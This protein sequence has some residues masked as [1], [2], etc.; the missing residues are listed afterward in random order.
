[1]NGSIYNG[2]SAIISFQGALDIESNNVANVN[3]IGF[4][5]DSVSFNDLM[6]QDGVGKGVTRNDPLKD[7]SQGG[8][9]PSN[10][11]YDFAISG[12]G[13]FTLQDPMEPEKLFYSRTGQFSSNNENFLTNSEG[14]IVMGVAPTVTGDVITSE[15]ENN[16]TSTVVDTADSF[17]TLNTYTSNYTRDAKEMQSVITNLSTIEAVINGTAT[18]EEN[19]IIAANPSLMENYEKYKTQIEN[20]Q[21][22]TSGDNY[23]SIDTILNDID[24]IITNYSNALK[25]FSVNSV[26]GEIASKAKSSVVF[27]TTLTENSVNTIEISINGIKVQQNFDTS[28]ENTLKLFSDKINLLAGVTSS[29]DSTTGELTIDSMISGQN[30]IVKNAKV[31]DQML[32]VDKIQEASGSGENLIT[33]LYADLQE[34]LAKVGASAVTN[35]SEIADIQSG[36]VPP[37][38]AIR[39]DLNELGMSTTLYEKIVNGNSLATASYPQ[40]E[41]EDGNIYL[42]DGDARFLVGRL[43]PVTFTNVSGLEP[44]GDNVYTQGRDQKEPIYIA[45]SAEVMGKF[46]ENSNIDLSESLVNL[47]IWQ[48]GFEAN[49]K[50]ITT[51]D[52]LLKTALALK[53][54]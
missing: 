32:S 5:S 38:E 46:V 21:T 28:M 54:T 40:I 27:P 18:E 36:A 45:D 29:I 10:S 14:L 11:E 23:K 19:A 35:K 37:L 9:K 49:S 16:I 34:N 1:M 12:P 15:F 17:Y 26:E 42:T 20:I 24:E 52:E 53:T 8:I 22:I 2:K 44:Q 4:K 6:Y 41:S 13:F 33:A 47:M 30:M 43:L 50:T 31:N 48:K 39:L 25:L 3:T 7:F 51:S